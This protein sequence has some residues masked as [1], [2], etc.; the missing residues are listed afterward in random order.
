[1]KE[2]VELRDATSTRLNRGVWRFL[3]LVSGPRGDTS[4][5]SSQSFLK[6]SHQVNELEDGDDKVARTSRED[7]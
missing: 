2:H 3:I 1:M 4:N 5:D 7:Y 6:A